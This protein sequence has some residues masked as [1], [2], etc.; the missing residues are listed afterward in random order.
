MIK[1]YWS[2]E[3]CLAPTFNDSV[4]TLS[5]VQLDGTDDELRHAVELLDDRAHLRPQ[6]RRVCE[7][8]Q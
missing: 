6:N 5:A 8:G 7:A 4:Q 2:R 1:P 3:Q